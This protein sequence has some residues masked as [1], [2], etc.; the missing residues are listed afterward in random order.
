MRIKEGRENQSINENENDIST[1]FG[2][3]RVAFILLLVI[4]ENKKRDFKL[5]WIKIDIIILR[6]I[7]YSQSKGILI[8]D[9]QWVIN[10]KWKLNNKILDITKN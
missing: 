7:W 3:N 4:R 10:F 6:D 9:N 2:E 1:N 8:N 5:I